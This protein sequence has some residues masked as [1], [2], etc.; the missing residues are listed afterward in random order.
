MTAAAQSLNGTASGSQNDATSAVAS[1]APRQRRGA[2]LRREASA[3][4]AGQSL[5]ENAGGF[6]SEAATTASLFASAAEEKNMAA[7]CTDASTI[8]CRTHA[9]RCIHLH[10]VRQR[11]RYGHPCIDASAHT[12]IQ[13][14]TSARL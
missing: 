11:V 3:V 1:G 8:I 5:E 2:G 13:M 14:H 12:R 4:V 6:Q 9:Y 10:A 7:T